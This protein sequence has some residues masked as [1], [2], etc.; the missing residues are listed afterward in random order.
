MKKRLANL[1]IM[2]KRIYKEDPK[3]KKIKE[4]TQN[5][6]LKINRS[7]PIF[8]PMSDSDA[9]NSNLDKRRDSNENTEFQKGLDYS[10]PKDFE[11]INECNQSHPLSNS[12]DIDASEGSNIL[13]DRVVEES[14]KDSLGVVEEYI[15]NDRKVDDL[16]DK[17]HIESSETI[18][19][20]PHS[21]LTVKEEIEDQV[22]VITEDKNIQVNQQED[23][24]KKITPE[25]KIQE[26]IQRYSD[27][28]GVSYESARNA[29]FKQN[30]D[31]EGVR[32]ILVFEKLSQ[33]IDTPQ[34]I[35]KH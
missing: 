27:S 9:E 2:K 8:R 16:N 7:K 6:A 28:F 13:E 18:V 32:K 5:S 12:I 11:D 21:N 1:E 24:P 34:P 4:G 29:Y 10:T 26:I 35:F 19:D 22:N 14:C 15:E 23:L 31:E 17:S 30:G 3:Q 25:E 33:Y 20:S